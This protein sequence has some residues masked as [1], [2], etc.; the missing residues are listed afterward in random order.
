M[1]SKTA[2]SYTCRLSK[3]FDFALPLSHIRIMSG[4]TTQIL[5]SDLGKVISKG[6]V[7]GTQDLPLKQS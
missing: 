5:S 6:D 7:K 4:W 1:F 2:S 3:C